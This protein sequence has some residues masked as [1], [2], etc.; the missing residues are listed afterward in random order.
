MA[1]RL[2]EGG[3][4]SYAPE[5]QSSTII[6]GSSSS[7][8]SSSGRSSS[9]R[10]SRASAAQLAAS[11]ARAKAAADKKSAEE[12]AKAEAAKK[13]AEELRQVEADSKLKAFVKS[14]SGKMTLAEIER[15]ER[16]TE[17]FNKLTDNMYTQSTPITGVVQ[18]YQRGYKENV[19]KDIK[20]IEAPGYKEIVSGVESGD[21]TKEEGFIAASGWAGQRTEQIAQRDIDIKAYNIQAKK[22]AEY[23]KEAEKLTAKIESKRENIQAQID[24][25]GD[26]NKLS[27]EFNKYVSN[28]EKVLDSMA[29]RLGS[30]TQRE[31]ESFASNWATGSGKKTLNKIELATMG[32]QTEI[33]KVDY[34]K[35]LVPEFGKGALVGAGTT[36]GLA[37]ISQAAPALGAAIATGSTLIAPVTVTAFGTKAGYDIFKGAQISSRALEIGATPTEAFAFGGV[38]TGTRLLPTAAFITGA[39]AGSYAV[40]QY[41]KLSFKDKAL[42]DK[43][44]SKN[45]DWTSRVKKLTTESQIKAL[46][47]SASEKAQLLKDFKVSKSVS[48]T[49]SVPSKAG[50]T[51]AEIKALN[52]ANLKRITYQ[53][54]SVD[55][56]G[57]VEG[58]SVSNLYGGRGIYQFGELQVGQLTGKV[59]DGKFVG[60]QV[61]TKAQPNTIWERIGIGKQPEPVVKGMDFQRITGKGSVKYSPD[62]V[63]RGEV[64]DFLVSSNRRLVFKDGRWFRSDINPEFTSVKSG[65]IGSYTNFKFGAY[66]EG[67]LVVTEM[68]KGYTS[69][70]TKTKTTQLKDLVFLNKDPTTVGIVKSTPLVAPPSS[71]VVKVQPVP[72]SIGKVAPP[73]NSGG[74]T[75]T[76]MASTSD[77][78]FGGNMYYETLT[79]PQT[80]VKTMP[81]TIGITTSPI[82]GTVTQQI[83]NIMLPM[84]YTP[85]KYD[86]DTKQLRK[87]QKERTTMKIV[88]V[89]PITRQIWDMRML[90]VQEQRY[91]TK[92]AISTKT[93]TAQKIISMPV[94]TP[95]I[96]PL[97]TPTIKPGKTP[98][99][100]IPD[101][102]IPIPPLG[103]SVRK[104]KPGRKLIGGYQRNLGTSFAGKYLNIKGIGKGSFLGKYTG[105]EVRGLSKEGDIIGINS[106]PQKKKKKKK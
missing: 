73:I 39:S 88:T 96:S 59:V 7:G 89:A 82:T 35:R 63:L 85:T 19:E 76:K 60:T 87:R 80:I 50:L 21:I 53:T 24:E 18:D 77:Y 6:P 66:G 49:E 36:V 25:G 15:G 104:Q 30:E 17:F 41:G 23:D 42:V 64:G 45:P 26:Y 46:K 68:A 28:E 12:K 71:G 11:R 70:A 5:R 57:G 48:I 99:P 10:S 44:L 90:Q 4:Q 3:L 47:V 20:S 37:A 81:Q 100:F 29:G 34:Y 101:F 2:V 52:K 9:G 16:G 75:I 86:I 94:F 102:R 1:V 22:Q 40:S 98:L 67:D 93:K 92:T 105:F 84:F 31:V 97:V 103:G 78:A 62:N 72:S 33:K 14:E 27:K 54:T 13:A 56:V 91:K 32:I 58:L 74:R 51:S 95:R 106:K 8:S 55:K 79:S 61:V 69:L 65:D 43:A 83:G 38:E